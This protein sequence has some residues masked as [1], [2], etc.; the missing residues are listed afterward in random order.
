MIVLDWIFIVALSFAT[1]CVAIMVMSLILRA[2]ARKQ[3][4]V[5]L[6]KRPKNKRNKKKWLL[7]KKNLS[8][9]KK[10]YTVRSIIFLFLTLI[11]SGISYGSL[12]Y[13]S[14]RLNMEDSKAVVKGYYL[15]RELDEEM[16]KAKETDNPV[17]SG[18]NIQ[19]LSARFSS[20]G[21]QTATVRNT[22]ERQAL[23]N[24]Y[25]KYMKELGINLSS[26]PT[27]FFEDETMYDSFMADI[28]KIKGFEKEIFDLFSVN[29]KSLEKR[30]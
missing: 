30:E 9:K 21:V 8:K 12:Y 26:Q 22:V 4:K 11:L 5:I 18:K 20:Y 19:V 1:L 17:K 2:G 10:K 24:K 13:Q 6:K 7:H 16:K 29:K 14:I 23:L 3:L 25:Y 28:K 27:Q 15:L